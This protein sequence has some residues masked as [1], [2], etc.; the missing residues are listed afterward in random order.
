[1]KTTDLKEHI[2][3]GKMDQQLMNIYSDASLLEYQKG[4]YCKLIEE[5]EQHF[6]P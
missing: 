6:G 3:T 2:S 1:M 5:F 4:R